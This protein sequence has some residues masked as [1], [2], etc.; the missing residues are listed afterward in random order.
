[1]LGYSGD[2]RILKNICIGIKRLSIIGFTAK[3][4]GKKSRNLANRAKSDNQK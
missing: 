1:M 2:I 4:R 3:I